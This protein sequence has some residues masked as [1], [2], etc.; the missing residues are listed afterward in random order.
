M[1]SRLVSTLQYSKETC[2]N[3]DSWKEAVSAQTD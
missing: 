2:V 3:G 1:A